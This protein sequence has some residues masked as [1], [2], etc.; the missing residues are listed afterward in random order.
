MGLKLLLFF[1]GSLSVS[2]T[3][4]SSP[5]GRA[6]G[7]AAPARQITI[8][9]ITDGSRYALNEKSGKEVVRI[10][11]AKSSSP[12]PAGFAP[13]PSASS[14]IWEPSAKPLCIFGTETKK[15]GKRPS[16]MFPAITAGW[17]PPTG[18]MVRPFCS[19]AWSEPFQPPP[20]SSGL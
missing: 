19:A 17:V 3:A 9:A 7:P 12:W 20:A 13:F 11:R 18:G 6:K 10:C 5:K 16:G 4:A 2:L 1:C 14:A 8:C 15:S